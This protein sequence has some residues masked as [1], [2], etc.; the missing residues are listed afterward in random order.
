MRLSELYTSV[1]GEGPN[2]GVPIQFIRFAGCNM[3]CAG[4][5]CDTPQAIYPEDY[6]HEWET[7]SIDELMERIELKPKHLCIT[8]GEPFLQKEMNKFISTVVT[9]GYKVDIFT[10]GSFLF[11]P[12]AARSR[13]VFIIMDWKLTGSGEV[14]TAIDNRK[15]NVRRIAYAAQIAKGTAHVKFV[16][17]HENDL[18]EAKAWYDVLTQEPEIRR[19]IVFW[20]GAA[21]G[22][23]DDK[24]IVDFVLHH[25]VPW[26]LNQQT[27]KRIWEPEARY[28]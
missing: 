1:Q 8:G 15:Q 21:W 20:V 3:R 9:E 10:N 13:D 26:R 2:T 6:R 27:H 17:K 14:T 16:V 5:P 23:I 18:W 7:I 12:F 11:P 25:E 22:H 24:Q 4:W 28:T 19:N